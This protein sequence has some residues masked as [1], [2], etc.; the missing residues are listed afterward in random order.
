M[1]G[2]S[3]SLSSLAIEARLTYV[4]SHLMM[5]VFFGG[6]HLAYGIY[7]KVTETNDRSA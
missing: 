3:L 7:V 6:L 2:T 4:T 1:G 5:G